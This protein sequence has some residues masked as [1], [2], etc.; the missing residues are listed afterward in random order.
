MK[1]PWNNRAFLDR[2]AQREGMF[3]VPNP[4]VDKL[5]DA[6]AAVWAKARGLAV[7]SGPGADCVVVMLPW[8]CDE[9]Q[10]LHA[11]GFTP[12]ICTDGMFIG[13]QDWCWRRATQP[14]APRL[15]DLVRYRDE[16][17]VSGTGKVA[18]GVL[19]A[20]GQCVM[21]WCTSTR[22]TAIYETIADLIRIHG[23]NGATQVRWV[24]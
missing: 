23:H 20:D 15:F 12:D 10:Q 8:D 17:G 4:P 9:A 21:R 19:F 18:E 7:F 1:N 5:P 13:E 3:R 2:V 22:S 6:V 11:A 24:R 16:T 14:L